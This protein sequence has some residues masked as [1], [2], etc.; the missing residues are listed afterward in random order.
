MALVQ[1]SH[2]WQ[3]LLRMALQL[4]SRRAHSATAPVFVSLF[5]HWVTVVVCLGPSSQSFEQ[6]NGEPETIWRGGGT[7]GGADPILWMTTTDQPFGEYMPADHPHR[8]AT[9]DTSKSSVVDML[10][11]PVTYE[12]D[13]VVRYHQKVHL[14]PRRGCPKGSYD[15]IVAACVW[16]DRQD[17]VLPHYVCPPGSILNGDFCYGRIV[18]DYELD[19]P[20]NFLP[21]ED[22]V[23]VK[24]VV[25]T[26]PRIICPEG[27]AVVRA[28]PD[29]RIRL[30]KRV[31][32]V[33]PIKRSTETIEKLPILDCTDSEK[34]CPLP[35]KPTADREWVLECPGGGKL[36]RSKKDRRRKACK[37]DILVP[38]LPSK[39]CAK[40]FRPVE[41]VTFGIGCVK[42][43]VQD[44]ALVCPGPKPKLGPGFGDW[45]VPRYKYDP[46]DKC[47]AYRAKATEGQCPF[48][49]EFQQDTCYRKYFLPYYMDCSHLEG[50]AFF[51][52]PEHET[53]VCEYQFDSFK[54]SPGVSYITQ[55]ERWD[56][57]RIYLLSNPYDVKRA[58]ENSADI[59]AA[60][61]PPPPT[62]PTLEKIPEIKTP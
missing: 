55:R 5:Y 56:G 42:I 53:G 26:P 43:S 16:L 52:D 45:N 57:G 61:R 18:A 31:K 25:Y 8:L 10:D 28:S 12:P 17:K 36:V 46:V 39:N 14:P 3:L 34:K 9:E 48:G 50:Y 60:F 7:F 41:L 40:G 37:I 54:W 29:N 33:A 58:Y 59:A 21:N 62:A 30:C 24:A 23:C 2:F 44:V 1:L 20:R 13:R 27:F 47:V 22:E 4:T 35:A 11:T 32:Y 38:P 51:W 49:Y 19:C 15:A 6:A